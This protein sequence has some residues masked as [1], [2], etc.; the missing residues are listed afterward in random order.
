M[1]L[2]VGMLKGGASR[3][4]TAIYLA[5]AEARLGKSVL[6]VDA[7]PANGSAFEWVEDARGS[8][9]W[10]DSVGVAYWPIAGLSRHVQ[11]AIEK[12]GWESVI[13]DTGN[14]SEAL[15]AALMVSDQLLVALAPTGME[16]T[17]LE[18]TLRAAAEIGMHRPLELSVLLTRVIAN[19]KSKRE[20]R[21]VLESDPFGLRVLKT[22]VP[23]LERIA[24]AQGTAPADL[25]P[26]DAV[27][28]ELH[29]IENTRS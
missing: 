15:K 28:A 19:S 24:N 3:T 12:D 9:G 14:D 17:R 16:S 20:A 10:P 2:A 1:R 11:A 7:D 29:D 25:N 5:L 27:L 22:E 8:G 18:P 26:Y 13:C 21:E 4:T 6:L 23:R